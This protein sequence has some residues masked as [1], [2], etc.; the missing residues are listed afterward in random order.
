M[1]TQCI[2]VH[3][4]TA[5]ALKLSEEATERVMSIW[6]MILIYLRIKIDDLPG[7]LFESIGLLGSFL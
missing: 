2:S 1:Y 7:L 3:I 6:Y 5:N 4:E